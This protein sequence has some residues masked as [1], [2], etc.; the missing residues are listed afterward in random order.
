[1]KMFLSLLLSTMIAASCQK[2][3]EQASNNNTA[4]TLMNVSYGPDTLQRMD[5]HLPAGRS[6]DSTKVIVL[7]HGGAWMEGD[8]R[9]FNSYIDVLKQRLPEYAIINMNYRLASQAG[10]HFPTQEN[11][12]QAAINHIYSKRNEYRISDKIVL[13]GASA[14]A[15]LALLHAYKHTTPVKIKAVVSFF[16]PSDLADMYNSQTNAFYQYA[17]GLLIGGTPTANPQVYNQSSPTYFA[18]ASSAPTIL[19]HG[20]NDPLVSISQSIALHAKLQAAGVTSQL[21]TYPNEGHGW[22][23]SSLDD[24]FTK[25]IAFLRANVQ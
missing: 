7:I 14:G 21:V 23:G 13:L 20:G 22:I 16:G 24:S 17:L 6:I 4:Q 5:L 11:D 3:I 9:D 18:N 12:V 19:L 15:H 1:M 10:N 25:I 2:S 8:K